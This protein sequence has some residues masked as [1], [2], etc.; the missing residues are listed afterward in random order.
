MAPEISVPVK[1]RTLGNGLRV[2]LHE[3]RRLPVVHVAL[4]YHVGS[5]NEQPWRTGFAHL[6]EHLM[7]EG[8]RHNNSH[9]IR[10][11]ERAGASLSAGGV[12]GT[13]S[14]DRTNYYETVPKEAL[15]LALWAES[16][17]MAYL[18]DVLDQTKLDTQREVVRNERLQ[19]MDNVP[20]GTAWEKMFHAL[21]PP[22]HPYSWDVIGDMAHLAAADLSE[23]HEFFRTW[24]APNNAVLVVAGDYD[25]RRALELVRRYFGSIPPGRVP[26]R[27]VFP[28]VNRA[29][30]RRIVVPEEVPHARLYCGWSTVPFFH[31]DEPALDMLSDVLSD[32]LNSRL[33]RRMV[34]EDRTASDVSAFHYSLE[35]GGLTGVVATARPEVSLSR[36]RDQMDEELTRMADEGPTDDEL[37]RV[38]A[39]TQVAFVGALERLATKADLL[40]R[41]A[42]FTGDPG[43]LSE[44]WVRYREVSREDLQR[45]ARKYLL[46][47]RVELLYGESEAEGEPPVVP[48]AIGPGEWQ[49][50]AASPAPRDPQLRAEPD[51]SRAP[52]RGRRG[53]VEPPFPETREL[54]NGIRL[55]VAPR[56]HLPKIIGTIMMPAGKRDEPR[57]LAGLASL[58]AAMLSRGTKNRTASEF[59]AEADRVGAEV[60]AGAGTEFVSVSF[61][62]LSEHLRATLDLTA[63]LL[64]N[65]AF[66]D[67]ELERIVPLRLDDLK[68]SRA[69]PTSVLRRIV[70]RTAFSD[71]H[72]YGWRG[73]E[74]TLPGISTADLATFHQTHFLPGGAQAVVCGDLDPDRAAAVFEEFFGDWA[75]A[76]AAEREAPTD[77]PDA[78]TGV[79]LHPTGK[80]SPQAVVA[81]RKQG[82][83]RDSEDRHALR[84]ALH[85]LGGGFSSRLNLNLRERMGATY[86][87][88][89]GAR[90]L[91]RRSLLTASAS[92]NIEQA[93]PA[94]RELLSEV[95]GLASGKRPIRMWELREAKLAVTRTYA[96]RFE[97]LGGVCGVIAAIL[98]RGA[99]LS[100]IRDFPA[101]VE[102]ITRDE[103]AE[104]A[105]RYLGSDGSALV[106]VGDEERLGPALEGLGA[107]RRVDA[108]GAPLSGAPLS[109]AP[110]SAD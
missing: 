40:A 46:G 37:L 5:K 47:P 55:S 101:R 50:P 77:P 48:V 38:K 29:S 49:T 36:L 103:V 25:E 8:S 98:Q 107:V 7:F 56:H 96:Q 88:F 97:T 82:P 74:A 1:V 44:H 91:L 83:G 11:M 34:Y 24:Y 31:Q 45:A 10:L 105:F 100:D 35:S 17:R 21:F 15:G 106:A 43:K 69:D 6:F 58:T 23:V 64:F 41:Y 81:W 104:A 3:D 28:S 18:L 102:A 76:R 33:Y 108:E 14:H 60:G 70:R 95:D 62:C 61:S 68:E 84:L 39:A 92:L 90:Q 9:F 94:I 27:P 51:R 42:T 12:N 80:E 72:P 110:L 71:G 87:A 22:G 73:D 78:E 20:Y 32:G 54:G 52:R 26:G 109:G 85:I 30:H 2:L 65:P 79:L 89:T 93:A 63:D 57:R 19:R 67:V 16:D 53:H 99:P 59:E 75:A 86:G 13:T 66:P 4:W